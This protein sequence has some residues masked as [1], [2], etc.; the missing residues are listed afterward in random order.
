MGLLTDAFIATEAELAAIRLEGSSIPGD[1]FP[2]VPGK[3]IDPL[4]LAYL[5]AIVTEQ[6]AE[7]LVEMINDPIGETDESSEQWLYPFSERLVARLATLTADQIN[8]Y[9]T[10]W[11]SIEEWRGPRAK[12]LTPKAAAM[13]STNVTHYLHALCQLASQ[14]QAEGKNMYM[15]ICL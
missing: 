10:I 5:E 6:N 12:P 1:A 13:Y 2:T 9:G 11:A 7:N 14:A 4:K 3:N 15:W 8:H